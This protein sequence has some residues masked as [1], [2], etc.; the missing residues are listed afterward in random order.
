MQK[1]A[2]SLSG[3]AYNVK[4]TTTRS[5][6]II[7]RFGMKVYCGKD[8]DGNTKKDFVNVKLFGQLPKGAKEIEVSGR[9]SVDSWEKDG[10]KRKEVYIVAD[11]VSCLEEQTPKPPK[12]EE[13]V[14]SFDD[15]IPWGD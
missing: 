2:V 6:S 14:S 13:T 9:I 3:Y 7:S 4:E 5:G 15:D 8:A 12:K 1:N 11:N 10:V